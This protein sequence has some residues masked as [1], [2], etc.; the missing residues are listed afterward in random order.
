MALSSPSGNPSSMVVA[1]LSPPSLGC[2]LARNGLWPVSPE[3]L[4]EMPFCPGPASG[5]FCVCLCDI[6]QYHQPVRLRC[7][8]LRPT[9]KAG[10]S[11]WKLV[12]RKITS[13]MVD[14]CWQIGTHLHLPRWD[15]SEA[16]FL[17]SPRGLQQDGAIQT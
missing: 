9:R 11:P 7:S 10:L 15:G 13:R 5:H 4:L 1:S 14:G 8:E 12:P 6:F 17:R 16:C 3:S 2:F